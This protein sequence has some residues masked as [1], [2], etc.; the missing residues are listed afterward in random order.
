MRSENESR[1][2]VLSCYALAPATLVLVEQGSGLA[3]V[4]AAS[5]VVASLYHESEERDFR[6]TDYA[7]AFA[8]IAAN[9]WMATH[10]VSL[11]YPLAGIGIVALALA[12]Y[13]MA[14]RR[15]YPSF[16]SAW[17]ALSGLAGLV[18]AAGYRTK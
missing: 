8:V 10:A 3:P 9:V 17:H 13:V 18:L 6:A 14:H 15:S 11:V 7:L 16:H 12:C 2:L 4:Y 1:T 5:M